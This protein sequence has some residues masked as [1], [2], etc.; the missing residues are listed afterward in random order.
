MFKNLIKKLTKDYSK[1]PLLWIEFDLNS[2]KQNGAKN[3][4]LAKIHPE[5]RKDKH[6]ENTLRDL[7]DYIRDN[8][9]MDKLIL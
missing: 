9:D 6:I 5:I 7:I 1:I 4:C 2:Y 8:Y 3:S